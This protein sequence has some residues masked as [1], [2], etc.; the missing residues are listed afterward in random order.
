MGHG[1]FFAGILAQVRRAK[2]ATRIV[3]ASDFPLAKLSAAGHHGNGNRMGWHRFHCLLGFCCRVPPKLAFE[4]SARPRNGARLSQCYFYAL[5]LSLS[6]P[7]S[8]SAQAPARPAEPAL[9]LLNRDESRLVSPQILQNSSRTEPRTRLVPHVRNK[10]RLLDTF[11]RTS[12][13]CSPASVPSYPRCVRNPF[14]TEPSGGKKKKYSP[15]PDL[16]QRRMSASGG[17]LLSFPS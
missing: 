6:L 1:L 13:A 5:S 7:L 15:G 2:C 10:I 16:G 3:S 17:E 12:A 9:L 8:L 11:P 14:S 4:M